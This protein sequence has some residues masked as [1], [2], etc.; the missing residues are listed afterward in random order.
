MFE[1]R[2]KH[3]HETNGTEIVDSAKLPFKLV[4]RDTEL[5]PCDCL[6]LPIAQLG[7][8]ITLVND[9]VLSYHQI[10][11]TDGDM[12][13][14]IFLILIQRI[15]LVDVLHIRHRLI[16]RVIT[17]TTGVGVRRVTLGIVDIFVSTQ[18]ISLHLVIIAA[19][20]IVVVVISGVIVN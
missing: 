17:L 3:T 20:E 11:W 6:L 4:Y 16:R 13:L 1:S 8:V 9:I 14:I 10:F 2:D 12:V 5:I 19:T 18:D 15:V 7:S